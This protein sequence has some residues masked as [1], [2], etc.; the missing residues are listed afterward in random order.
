MI[1]PILHETKHLKIYNKHSAREKLGLLDSNV[2]VFGLPGRLTYQKGFDI[3]LELVVAF[4]SSFNNVTFMIIGDGDMKNDLSDH[5]VNSDI[6]HIVKLKEYQNNISAGRA[7]VFMYGRL[8]YQDA[9]KNP[10][11]TNFRYVYTGPWGG[12][13]KLTAC[14]EGNDAT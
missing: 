4:K 10:W 7:G 9:F 5:I 2:K 11:V 8:T 6:S 14:K 13:Q 12:K 3:F 1:L